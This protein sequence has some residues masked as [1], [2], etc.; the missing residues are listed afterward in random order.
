MIRAST[1]RIGFYIIGKGIADWPSR[2]ARSTGFS[3]ACVVVAGGSRTR[4]RSHGDYPL[5]RYRISAAVFSAVWAESVLQAH[6]SSRALCARDRK[7]VKRKVNLAALQFLAGRARPDC[8]C[9]HSNLHRHRSVHAITLS[10]HAPMRS[11]AGDSSCETRVG[12]GVL[13]AHREQ[14]WRSNL[15]SP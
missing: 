11:A 6:V 15:R 8:S 5:D 14:R 9:C 12:A 2:L 3:C 13:A 4:L 7:C 10:P 1:V